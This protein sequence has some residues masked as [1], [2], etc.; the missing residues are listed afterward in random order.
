[1][2]AARAANRPEVAGK[3]DRAWQFY[4]DDDASV[5]DELRAILGKVTR[6]RRVGRELADLAGA[7][8]PGAYADLVRSAAKDVAVLEAAQ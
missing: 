4:S 8:G 5:G 7:L 1:M 6:G 2:L 3:L